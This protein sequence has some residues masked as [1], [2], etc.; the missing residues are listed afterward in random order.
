MDDD[1]DR[2]DGTELPDLD[3]E[4]GSDARLAPEVKDQLGDADPE[5][6]GEAHER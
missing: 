5:D 2:V 4:E 3:D 1:E 6:T